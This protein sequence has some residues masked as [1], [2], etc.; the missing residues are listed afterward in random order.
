MK[1]L[2]LF[3]LFLIISVSVSCKKY[4]VDKMPEYQIH[5]GE[6]GGI[7]GAI[8]EYCLLENGQLF[9]KK[10]FTEDFV[11]YK[12]VKKKIAKE[13]F[14]TC[15]DINIQSIILN[16]PG[17]KYYY[18]SYETPAQKHRI[19]WGRNKEEVPQSVEDLYG[20]LKALVLTKK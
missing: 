7:T 1:L 6:G 2:T 18:I 13:Q 11:A 4:T 14:K 17:D 20:Q 15:E 8:T 12:T 10:H 19:T 5:F 16:N 3:C 9:D